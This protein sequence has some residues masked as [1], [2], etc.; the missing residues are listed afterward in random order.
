MLLVLRAA[1]DRVPR[2]ARKLTDEQ[3]AA[4][5]A[6]RLRDATKV[7]EVRILYFSPEKD[8]NMDDSDGGGDKLRDSPDPFANNAPNGIGTSGSAGGGR[9]VSSNAG[10]GSGAVGSAGHRSGASG[11]AR[12]GIE[13]SAS[14]GGGTGASGT[15]GGVP[16]GG[17]GSCADPKCPSKPGLISGSHRCPGAH[18]CLWW[19]GGGG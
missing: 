3:A 9:G 17:L 4:A 2:E 10:G 18:A 11:G 16:A 14:A 6:E 1:I 8:D 19:R 7:D 13:V 15:A 12:D 5:I